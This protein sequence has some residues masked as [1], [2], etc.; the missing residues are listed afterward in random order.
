MNCSGNSFMNKFFS[1]KCFL[2][3]LF[4]VQ[5]KDIVVICEV[6]SDNCGL[7]N[8]VNSVIILEE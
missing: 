4:G 7:H 6:G 1:F 8:I 3:R 2:L 5:F